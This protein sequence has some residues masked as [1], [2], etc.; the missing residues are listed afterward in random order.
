[1]NEKFPLG[2]HDVGQPG[3]SASFLR[4]QPLHASVICPRYINTSSQSITLGYQTSRKSIVVEAVLSSDNVSEQRREKRRLE[5]AMSC[6]VRD[7]PEL[8]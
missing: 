5:V 6:P 2:E 4:A 7:T 3:Q 1:M 8:L